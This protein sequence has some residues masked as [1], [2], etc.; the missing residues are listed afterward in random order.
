MAIMAPPIRQKALTLSRKVDVWTSVSPWRAYNAAA[1][2][3]GQLL[4]HNFNRIT[5]TPADN[6]PQFPAGEDGDHS[7]TNPT[8][9]FHC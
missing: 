5:N 3:R 4:I 6:L 2:R 1:R 8:A 7:H 9:A